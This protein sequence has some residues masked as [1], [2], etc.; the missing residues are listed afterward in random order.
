MPFCQPGL[1]KWE[2]GFLM[3]NELPETNLEEFKI[4]MKMIGAPDQVVCETSCPVGSS[5]EEVLKHTRVRSAKKKEMTPGQ[6]AIDSD[7][8]SGMRL[9]DTPEQ[10]EVD[11]TPSEQLSDKS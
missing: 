9:Q 4:T 10:Q 5:L 8:G 3:A 6:P 11:E 2:N 1:P 7:L